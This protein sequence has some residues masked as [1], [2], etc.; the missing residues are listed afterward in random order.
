MAIFSLLSSW[1]FH[2]LFELDNTVG[3]WGYWGRK[4]G[5]GPWCT[6]CVFFSSFSTSAREACRRHDF[7][8]L[9][10]LI[11]VLEKTNGKCKLSAQTMAFI[12][13]CTSQSHGASLALCLI[14][15]H[16]WFFLLHCLSSFEINHDLKFDFLL[17]FLMG[18]LSFIKLLQLCVFSA[19]MSLCHKE[20]LLNGNWFKW[21]SF[22]KN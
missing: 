15:I 17:L 7:F 12:C 22:L 3:T 19:N 11:C 16:I 18:S 6:G 20:Q 1:Q 4:A 10:L 21:L 2:F 9:C 13:L 5:I 8:V 14:N